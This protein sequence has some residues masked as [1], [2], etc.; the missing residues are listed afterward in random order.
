MLSTKVI[1]LS[2]G[3]IGAALVAQ[4][5]LAG[6]HMQCIGGSRERVSMAWTK[7]SRE[8]ICRGRATKA[9]RRDKIDAMELDLLRG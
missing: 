6:E 3:A 4:R 5:S 9:V 1:L 2:P 8:G 7:W